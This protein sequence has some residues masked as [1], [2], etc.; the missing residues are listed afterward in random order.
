[1]VFDIGLDWG[2][3]YDRQCHPSSW[4]WL[5]PEQLPWLLFG[6]ASCVS[7]YPFTLPAVLW[8][9]NISS[10][11]NAL[12]VLLSIS[13]KFTRRGS[14]DAATEME[15]L[16]ARHSH[17]HHTLVS[18]LPDH[19]NSHGENTVKEGGSEAAPAGGSSG[20]FSCFLFL[21]HVP[22]SLQSGSLYFLKTCIHV[23]HHWVIYLWAI[24]GISW[25][26]KAIWWHT[27]NT[28]LLRGEASHSSLF[29]KGHRPTGLEETWKT[30][31]FSTL[32]PWMLSL[33]R[34]CPP[35]VGGKSLPSRAVDSFFQT[36]AISNKCFI[37][38]MWRK[39]VVW[40]E[41]KMASYSILLSYEQKSKPSFPWSM[42][43]VFDVISW[44]PP[45]I[46]VPSLLNKGEKKN[47]PYLL[48]LKYAR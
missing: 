30:V 31:I 13:G 20:S 18:D 24:L 35:S 5:F 32:V 17:S 15:S 36:A 7:W 33:K 8:K 23:L 39:H 38:F 43:Q 12:L 2:R 28:T 3:F 27:A 16:S 1:M 46:Y 48:L 42:F 44:L 45:Q 9:D 10:F 6:C 29:S 19:S 34:A 37:C 11:S 14:S 4:P 40:V 21:L 26:A 41:S 47:P 22:S 25:V